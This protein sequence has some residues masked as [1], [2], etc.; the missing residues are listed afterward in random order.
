MA[1][2]AADFADT[3]SQWPDLVKRALYA[4]YNQDIPAVRGIT[5][6]IDSITGEV[7]AETASV[8]THGASFRSNAAACRSAS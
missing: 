7:Q 6:D 4:G 2:D 3:S 5:A 1:Q 8:Q